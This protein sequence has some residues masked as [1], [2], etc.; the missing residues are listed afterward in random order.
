MFLSST[1][2]HL[3]IHNMH[4]V[5]ADKHSMYVQSCSVDRVLNILSQITTDSERDCKGMIPVP[6]Y[7][8]VSH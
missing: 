5:V 4:C 7:P 1:L 2:V 3:Y 8:R 6:T